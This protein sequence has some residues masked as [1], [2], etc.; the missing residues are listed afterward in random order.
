MKSFFLAI[1]SLFR[2]I[3][4]IGLIGLISLSNRA[5]AQEL[6]SVLIQ[7]SGQNLT[8]FEQLQSLYQSGTQPEVSDLVGWRS[9]RCYHPEQPS[10]P[11]N[12]MLAG[13][14]TP[15]P[16]H[17]PI[18]QK[19]DILS[20]Y[21]VYWKN[22]APGVFDDLSPDVAQN[23]ADFVNFQK[24]GVAAAIWANNSVYGGFRQNYSTSWAVRKNQ[25]YIVL[26]MI[27]NSYLVEMCYYFKLIR[28]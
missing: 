28:P 26:E 1:V 23:V 24:P 15:G 20:I 17:G 6:P 22:G 16:D 12:G 5:Q 10:T 8:V 7:G 4:L 13:W 2:F 3:G 19:N 18:Q 25:N 11:Y 21:P 14:T 9:G 27:Q